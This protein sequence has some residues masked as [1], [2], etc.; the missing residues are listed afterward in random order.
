M[1]K[2]SIKVLGLMLLAVLGLSFGQ[3]GVYAEGEDATSVQTT[4]TS[5]SITPVSNVITLAANSTYDYTFKVTNGG[6]SDMRFEVYA[7]PYS[8]TLVEGDDEYKLGFSN[9]NSYTQIVRW[10]SFMNSDG[11]F[12][13]R[14]IF[15][16][17]PGE[18]VEVAY[19][20]TTPVDIP[21]GGQYAVL[22][23]HTLSNSAGGSGIKT[24]ASP[25]LVIY[26]RSSGETKKKAAISGLEI[27]KEYTKKKGGSEETI[28][29]INASA[30]IK[31]EGN[32]DFTALG[33]LKVDSI[34]G[35]GGSYETE[36]GEAAISVIPES[37]LTL[38]D[39][40]KETPWFGFFK[41]TW[42]VMA[43]GQ[44]ETIESV[45][46]LIPAT[47]IIIAIIL[48]TALAFWIIILVRKRKARRSKYLV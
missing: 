6:D 21:G 17:G 26:G 36:S 16:A 27:K 44:T 8:Y 35:F 23:A 40:W 25:G 11:N 48:L 28:K 4:G 19:R 46:V 13:E 5:I 9:E 3:T 29:H 41:V 34:L 20:I 43:A 42:T 32:V 38:T 30:K 22:F 15:V 24:E 33:T 47:V 14:P 18:T 45:V 37:E 12:V 2:L 7:A 10:I 1:K 31:N 39:E